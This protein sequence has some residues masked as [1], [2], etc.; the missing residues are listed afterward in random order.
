MSSGDGKIA[1]L[2]PSGGAE[3]QLLD[4]AVRSMPS[5]AVTDLQSNGVCGRCIFR[6][7]GIHGHVYFSPSLCLPDTHSLLGELMHLDKPSMSP[8]LNGDG[9]LNNHSTSKGYEAEQE[10]CRVCLGILQFTYRDDEEKLVKSQTPG[11]LASTIAALLKREGHQFDSFS[12]EVSVPPITLE[13]E[14]SVRL[15]M[16]KKYGSEVWFKERFS[17]CISAKDAFKFA[18]T[19]ILENL[20]I[21]KNAHN[22]LMRMAFGM[23]VEKRRMCSSCR[24]YIECGR[25]VEKYAISTP[26][27]ILHY[28]EAFQDIKSG[29][30]S[31]RIRLTYTQAKSSTEPLNSTDRNEGYKR[32]KTGISDAYVLALAYAGTCNGLDAVN[33]ELVGGSHESGDLLTSKGSAALDDSLDELKGH[34]SS[35]C[36]NFPIE[37][38]TE[39][40]LL[41]FL[42]Y[43]TP[44]YIGGRYLKF[45]RSVSQTRWIIDDERMGEASVEEIIGDNIIP[46]CRGD[47]YKFHAAGREDI[48]VRMLGSGRPFLVEI[49][50]ARQVPSE[51]LIKEMEIRINNL[52]S[53]LVGVKNLKLVDSHGWTLMRE[54]EAE[55]QKQYCALVWI[56]RPLEDEDLQSIASVKDLKLLLAKDCCFYFLP[57][58]YSSPD[59]SSFFQ[60]VSQ[61]TPIRVLHRRSPL[62]R[63]KIIHWMK[64]E[65][66]EGSSQYFL[67]H[68]CT[69]AGTYI[70][71]FVHGDLGRTHPSIGSILCCR[72]EILQLDV[73]DVKM[74]CF[75][76]E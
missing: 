38:V 37:K 54:G 23:Q 20:L 64:I 12:L 57:S 31:C 17:E 1:P 74:D 32:R 41:N 60:Q 52:D 11:D 14:N 66:V 35:A 5:H 76:A 8:L 40:C 62:D 58:P 7:F 33:H 30:S 39:P 48:D 44:I 42:C 21:K 13:N 68:L 16:K 18:I 56:S 15:Y 61:R 46:M 69:Q 4:D 9:D 45:S 25:R 73:T 55:K 51:A 75:M 19:S 59:Y 53:K 71:E 47:L 70:K 29:P 67:L 6:L 63:E 10:F 72:A 43:R 24:P 50:N 22:L 34:G 65:K 27:L 2:V 28:S 49:Q 3:K 26:L 36:V